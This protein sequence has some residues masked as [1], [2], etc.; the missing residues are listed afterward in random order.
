MLVTADGRDTDTKGH[1]KRDSHGTIKT[2]EEKYI[3]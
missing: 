1:D 2:D 3:K